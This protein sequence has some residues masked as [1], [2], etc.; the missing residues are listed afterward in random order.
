MGAIG[1]EV[2]DG[3]GIALSVVPALS[4]STR[5]QQFLAKRKMIGAVLPTVRGG[6][7]WRSCD[8][9]VELGM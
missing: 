9:G 5:M 4:R 8:V 3:R 7:L 6:L 1:Q 2:M